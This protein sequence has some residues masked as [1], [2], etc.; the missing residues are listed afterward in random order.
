MGDQ[1]DAANYHLGEGIDQGLESFTRADSAESAAPEVEAVHE[2]PVVHGL[3]GLLLACGHG[4]T[5]MDG[6][7]ADIEEGVLIGNASVQGK[8]LDQGPLHEVDEGQGAGEVNLQFLTYVMYICLRMGLR[9]TSFLCR[10]TL[11]RTRKA[12]TRNVSSPVLHRTTILLS[13]MRH[14][15]GKVK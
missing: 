12:S 5:Q 1:L 4:I 8:Q 10:Q 9:K 11:T 3:V 13:S 7:L 14:C 2:L 15:F 6:K